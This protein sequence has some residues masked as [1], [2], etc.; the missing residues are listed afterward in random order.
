MGADHDDA[1]HDRNGWVLWLENEAAVNDCCFGMKRTGA[2]ASVLACAGIFRPSP[3][4]VLK[5][6]L[7]GVRTEK[8]KAHRSHVSWIGLWYEWAGRPA[9]S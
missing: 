9:V 6:Q 3:S 4:V 2:E 1:G 8:P 7:D 5:R